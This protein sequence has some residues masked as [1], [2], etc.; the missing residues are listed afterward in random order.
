LTITETPRCIIRELSQADL[1][2]LCLLQR[3][4][5]NNPAGC[6]FPESCAEPDVYLR[7]YIKFQYPFYGFGLFGIYIKPDLTF[8]GIAGYSASELPD[9]PAAISYALL[10]KYQHQGYARESLQSLLK[11]GRDRWQLNEVIARIQ[12]DNTDSVRLAK[13]MGVPI[14]PPL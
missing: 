2:S 1:S 8:A 5:N 9:I 10:K 3:E 7:D 12:P 11:E 13:D 4:N 6:F 14:Y